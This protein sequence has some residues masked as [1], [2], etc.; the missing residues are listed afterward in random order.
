[1]KIWILAAALAM[2]GCDSSPNAI[3][4]NQV[5]YESGFPPTEDR[6]RIEV[7]LIGGFKDHTAYNDRRAVFLFKDSE[8]GQEWIGVSGVGISEVGSHTSSC[9]KTTCTRRDER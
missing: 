7:T 2:T 6:G 3:A 4:A 1:M 8:T 9:G 5:V